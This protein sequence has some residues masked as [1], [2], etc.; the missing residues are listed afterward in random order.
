MTA[1]SE[2]CDRKRTT[3]GAPPVPLSEAGAGGEGGSAKKLG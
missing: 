3:G 1:N 2:N